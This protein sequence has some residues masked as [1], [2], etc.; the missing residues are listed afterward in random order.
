MAALLGACVSAPKPLPPK[1]IAEAERL[2]AVDK[3]QRMRAA[4]TL[5]A[6]GREGVGA[7]L[8]VLS[9]EEGKHS[10]GI[11]TVQDEAIR[12]LGD[13]AF[14]NRRESETATHGLVLLTLSPN[15][16]VAA[17]AAS[18]LKPFGTDLLPRLA[19]LAFTLGKRR[20]RAARAAMMVI[21][22]KHT[23]DLYVRML[24]EPELRLDATEAGVIHALHQVTFE[25]FGYD[26]AGTEVDRARSV[27]KWI[28]WWQETKPFYKNPVRTQELL[29]TR[30][31]KAQEA[32]LTKPP[33]TK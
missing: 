27:E 14:A 12:V 21:D 2:G 5:M 16:E 11:T 22:E 20:A 8:A 18:S 32:G 33:K 7:V 23:V 29:R 6:A 24:A 13:I 26:Q 19:G 17:R 4:S 1:L 3:G 15:P 30:D 31:E 28:T 25:H 9:R 10:E